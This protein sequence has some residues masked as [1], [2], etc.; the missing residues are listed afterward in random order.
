MSD[1]RKSMIWII[2]VLMWVLIHLPVANAQRIT[3][4]SAGG[5]FARG[6][7]SGAYEQYSTLLASF[8]RDP[9][10]LYGAG[11]S[12]IMLSAKPDEAADLLSR[13]LAASSPVRSAPADTRFY[14]ARALHL[15]GQFS[16]AAIEYEKYSEAAGRREARDRG[17]AGL[18]E[19]CNNHSGMVANS[20]TTNYNPVQQPVE[21]AQNP[22]SIVKDDPITDS[23]IIGANPPDTLP[24]KTD[25]LLSNALIMRVNADD[26]DK[27]VIKLSDS[28][29]I[30][31]GVPVPESITVRA[32]LTLPAVEETKITSADPAKSGTNSQG[33][34]LSDIDTLTGR[35][36][37]EAARPA[38]MTT[39]TSVVR[40]Q[41]PLVIDTTETKAP[42]IQPERR[43]S[44]FS[45]FAMKN[46][47]HYSRTN[48]VTVSTAFPPGLLYTVQLAVFRNPVDPSHFRRLYP[49][50]GVKVPGREL[51]TYYSGLFRTMADA[52]KSLG[53]IRNEGFK[54][55]FITIFMDGKS[56]SAER[57]AILEREW[58]RRGLPE[59]E[60]V[61]PVVAASAVV[62]PIVPAD[63]IPPTLLFR[64]E[65]LRAGKEDN[66]EL[67]EEVSRVAGDR[68]FEIMNPATGIYVYIVGKFLTFESAS[69]YAD[70]LR[71]NGYKDA[72]VAAY[73]GSREIPIEIALKLFERKN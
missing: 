43:D 71:R 66:K 59:W 21:R 63:T 19:Q 1:S 62:V 36:I 27:G 47:P 73:A 46:A 67:R 39:D 24:A 56:V 41:V 5:A 40:S 9:A 4:Q 55:A 18:I 45:I 3:G 15:S 26:A 51:T 31:A 54:D 69:A 14:Y 35:D 13:A 30:L 7:F 17:L 42:A 49:V 61:V 22:E 2:M 33:L 20:L 64:V 16:N 6:D 53:S 38:Q 70:L 44:V 37:A 68:G 29:L 28:L 57:G 34:A 23:Q 8:P 52:S 60:G 72:R 32:D 50:F 10:Y 25:I 58:R 12:L 11:V 65:V 48:P